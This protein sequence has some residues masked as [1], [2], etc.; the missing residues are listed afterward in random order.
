MSG[1]E[2]VAGGS[3][4]DGS[5]KLHFLNPAGAEHMLDTGTKRSRQLIDLSMFSEV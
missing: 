1:M 3:S 4:E 5:S 2:Q